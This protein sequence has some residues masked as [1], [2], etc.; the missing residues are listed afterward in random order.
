MARVL[1]PGSGRAVL[2]VTRPYLLGLPNLQRARR[3]DDPLRSRQRGIPGRHGIDSKASGERREKCAESR[4][5]GGRS[6]CETVRSGLGCSEGPRAEG[7]LPQGRESGKQGSCGVESDPSATGLATTETQGGAGALGEPGALWR[8]RAQHAVN[9]GGLFSWLLVLDRTGEP[10]PPERL[11]RRKGW[12]GLGL[13]RKRRKE[14]LRVGQ[15]HGRG[16]HIG[17]ADDD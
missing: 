4:E 15:G 13:Y 8:I 12:V 5:N 9:V 14:Q 10:A 16:R 3:K 17:C 6:K 2:L 1:R 7:I 11:D